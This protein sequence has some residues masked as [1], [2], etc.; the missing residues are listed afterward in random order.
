M[1]NNIN[2]PPR[3]TLTIINDSFGIDKGY[4]RGL[5]H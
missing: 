3:K 4:E 5:F 1:I 2:T